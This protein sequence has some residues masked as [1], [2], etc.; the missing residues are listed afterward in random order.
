[1][2]LKLLQW[3]EILLTSDYGRKSPVPH[4][5][6][7]PSLLSSAVFVIFTRAFCWS[8]QDSWKSLLFVPQCFPEKWCGFLK[9][10]SV[11]KGP[12]VM[13]VCGTLTTET[14]DWSLGTKVWSLKMWVHW[15]SHSDLETL[16][17]LD[18]FSQ[19]FSAYKITLST[20]S[21]ITVHLQRLNV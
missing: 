2:G 21:F 13:S 3:E 9:H 8:I 7:F 10:W 15:S 12:A 20:R 17:L 19:I 5:R 16:S 11:R 6:P 18:I 14:A 1:M 4:P